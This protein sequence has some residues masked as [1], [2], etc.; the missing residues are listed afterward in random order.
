MVR[1][2]ILSKLSILLMIPLLPS[3]GY[4]S[5]TMDLNE[6]TTGDNRQTASNNRTTLLHATF[7]D[8]QSLFTL[9]DKFV[10]GG[11]VTKMSQQKL[12]YTQMEQELIHFFTTFSDE[13]STAANEGYIRW[14]YQETFKKH[15]EDTPQSDIV[16]SIDAPI[17]KLLYV[18]FIKKPDSILASRTIISPRNLTDIASISTTKQSRADIPV[19]HSG[20]S[21]WGTEA[22][23]SDERKIHTRKAET[24]DIPNDNFR[25]EFTGKSLKANVSIA[26]P[27]EIE[28]ASYLKQYIIGQDDPMNELGVAIRRHYEG[29]EHNKQIKTKARGVEFKKSNILIIGQS[30]SGK[31]QSV[32]LIS[33]FLKERNINASLH[34]DSALGLTITGYTGRSMKDIIAAAFVANNYDIDATE[35]GIILIDEI[36]K[37][38]MIDN[39]IGKRDIAGADV[40]KECLTIFENENV[41]LIAKIKGREK[42]QIINTKNILFVCVGSFGGINITEDEIKIP[43]KENEPIITQ[44]DAFVSTKA[45]TDTLTLEGVSLIGSSKKEI[46]VTESQNTSNTKVPFDAYGKISLA[47]YGL[48]AEPILKV[49]QKRSQPRYYIE[50][51]YN[52]S[53]AE[54][55]KWFIVEFR[56][57]LSNVILFNKITPKILRKI[58]TDSDASIIKSQSSL[59]KNR[60]D[61]NIQFE[62]DALNIIAEKAAKDPTGA[63]SLENIVNKILKKTYAN[64]AAL[65]GTKVT[66]TKEYIEQRIPTHIEAE[67]T[68]KSMIS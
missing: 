26:I 12:L 34:Q 67:P 62:S 41:K 57:R 1:A 65:K 43:I 59:L 2:K 22:E 29:I 42:E 27:S 33:Q 4:T 25:E 17:W 32:A 49:K 11:P 18:N 30:G 47:H 24:F 68:W 23:N 10:R 38:G 51:S 63:R 48:Q 45:T 50:K 55:S 40:Q 39:A 3:V 13:T 19:M 14:L 56:A 5:S 58:L 20:A 28:I 61:I 9:L 16:A 15:P 44:N 60:Y 64:A 31:S 35:N 46:G 8:Y 36:D 54:L 52:V 37:I 66:I 6:L 53:D 7:D 21:S